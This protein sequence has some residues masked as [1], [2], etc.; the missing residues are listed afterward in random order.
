[1]NTNPT[2]DTPGDDTRGP[3]VHLQADIAAVLTGIE[4]TASTVRMLVDSRQNLGVAGDTGPRT[5]TPSPPAPGNLAAVSVEVDL[6]ATIHHQIRQTHH[7]LTRAGIHPTEPAPTE[8]I[9]IDKLVWQLRGLILD[10][11]D[12]QLLTSI[13]RDLSTAL[14]QADEFVQGR[15][16]TDLGAC[17][18]CLRPTL[19]IYFR[20][21]IIRCGRDRHTR[22]Y[23]PCVCPSDWCP[24]KHNPT[25]HRH[26]WHRDAGTAA[27]GWWALSDRLTLIRATQETPDA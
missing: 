9:T 19:T 13:H 10:T 3:T 12:Y 24:C 7:A 16:S 22:Q 18:H 23:E 26:T 21:G 8:P 20:D 2:P 15:V 4:A 5:K 17:P 27:H 25:S 11:T 14:E 6:W 1:M